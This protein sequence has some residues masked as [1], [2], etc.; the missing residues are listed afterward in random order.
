MWWVVL[1]AAVIVLLIAAWFVPA[2]RRSSRGAPNGPSENVLRE[3]EHFRGVSGPW[4]PFGNGG[5]PS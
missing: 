4:G 3:A 1:W 2:L 5:G